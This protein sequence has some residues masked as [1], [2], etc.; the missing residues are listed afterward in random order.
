MMWAHNCEITSLAW[1]NKFLSARESKLMRMHWK[2]GVPSSL[3]MMLMC[4]G[5]GDMQGPLVFPVIAVF[6]AFAMLFEL[7]LRS[8]PQPSIFCVEF[9]SGQMTIE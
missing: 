7:R 6:I 2:L 1:Q 9:A 3:S 4:C 8:P 5:C